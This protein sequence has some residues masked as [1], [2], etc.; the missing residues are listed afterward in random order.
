MI[1]SLI[2]LG[3]LLGLRHG[4]DWDHIAAISDLT[5]AANDRPHGFVLATFY[6]FGHALI[7]ILLGL[8]ALWFGTILPHRVDSFME[9]F[10]GVTLLFLAG[11]VFYT[12]WLTRQI[13][14][15]FQLKSRWMLLLEHFPHRNGS[16]ATVTA[17]TAFGI[18]AL[19]GIGAETASQALLLAGI[20]GTTS[21][22]EA[23]LLLGVFVIGLVLSNTGIAIL[24]LAGRQIG[25]RFGQSIARLTG[26]GVGLFSLLVGLFFVTG[27][28]QLLPHI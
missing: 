26:I 10:V 27:Q 15:P 23:S 4:I 3:F 14:A 13:G 5:G 12:L 22:A 7:V 24:A 17:H 25:Q 20:A 9:R 21:R 8:V 18:G 2:T 11:W 19:H 6:A 28:S 16:P 1:P